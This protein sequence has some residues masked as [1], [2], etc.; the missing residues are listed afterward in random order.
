M[1]DVL[2]TPLNADGRSRRSMTKNERPVTSSNA[3]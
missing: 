3:K 1:T 2:M